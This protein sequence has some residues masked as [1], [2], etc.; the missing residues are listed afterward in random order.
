MPIRMHTVVVGAGSIGAA[1]AY[2]LSREP[3]MRVTLVDRGEVAGENTSL[4]AALYTQVRS[5]SHHMSLVSETL[6]V[7]GEL[8]QRLGEPLGVQRPG[9]VHCATDMSTLGAQHTLEQ[10]ADKHGIAHREATADELARWFPWLEADRVTRA[11]FFPDDIHLD[12]VILSN[13]FVRAAR[14]Y[15][16]TV[17]TGTEV[18]GLSTDRGAVCEVHTSVGDLNCDAVVDAAGVWANLLTVPQ[19]V[20]LPMAPVRSF[21]FITASCPELFPPSQPVCIIPGARAYTRSEGGGLLI[22]LRD[23]PGLAVNP[24]ELP[25]HVR[26]M[27]LAD[28]N[29]VFHAM[30]HHGDTLIGLFPSLPD[31]GIRHV[32]GGLSTYTA[33]GEF[34]LGPVGTVRGL[35]AATGCSGSGVA[36]AGGLGR[37]IAAMVSGQRPFV[38]VGPFAPDRFVGVDAMSSDFLALCAAARAGKRDG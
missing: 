16:A 37:A 15:G 22:G 25:K 11:V 14:S 23:S 4:A 20:H 12:P 24:L 36:T 18:T 21:Y 19:G 10:N 27:S 1:C 33:D 13:A 17:L 29:M 26:Q 5:K 2:Y 35:Y 28:M 30:E 3:G 7:I 9:T 38:D 32:V 34:I 31:I 8:E 6:R